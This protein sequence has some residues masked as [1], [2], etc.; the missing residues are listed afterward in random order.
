MTSSRSAL[1]VL[2]LLAIGSSAAPTVTRAQYEGEPIVV[3]ETL[4]LHSDILD[5]DRPVLVYTPTGYDGSTTIYPVLYLLDGDAHFHHTTGIIDFL[6]QTGNMSQMIVVALPNT[7]RTRDL[8]PVTTTDTAN[9]FPAAGGA[10]DLTFNAY[11]SISPSLWWND[12]SL[13]AEVEPFF[14]NHSESDRFL[15]YTMGNEGGAMLSSAWAFAAA[16]QDHAPE[17][18]EWEFVLMEEETHGTIPHRTTYQ[19]L[20]LLYDTWSIP[21][22]AALADEGGLAA[23]DVHYAALSEKYGYEI[24]TPEAIVNQLGYYYIGQED[25]DQ[26]IAVLRRNVEV[27]PGSANV[28]DSLGDAYDGAGQFELARDNYEEAVEL[29]EATHHPFL[30]VYR[31]NLER[32]QEKIGT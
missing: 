13:I 32:I 2:A 27:Y 29:A 28:Y 22:F 3:G 16:L 8:T 15:Y 9:N 7:D 21:S 17:T 12:G 11:V 14:A 10:D 6:S 25:F 1:F 30:S 19:A 26:A 18:F 4:T 23:F 24:A 31:A 20:E 5:E